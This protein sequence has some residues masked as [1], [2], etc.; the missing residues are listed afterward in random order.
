MTVEQKSQV[1]KILA[2]TICKVPKE[3]KGDVLCFA[4]FLN[5]TGNIVILASKFYLETSYK[6]KMERREFLVAGDLD[7]Y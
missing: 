6:R 4:D 1:K 2:T 5:L 3:N 7:N